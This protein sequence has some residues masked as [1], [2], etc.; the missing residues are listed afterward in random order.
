[1]QQRNFF[2]GCLVAFGLA[3]GTA[4]CSAA[5]APASS[6]SAETAGT[7]ALTGLSFVQASDDY[8]SVTFTF[9]LDNTVTHATTLRGEPLISYGTYTVSGNDVTATIDFGFGHSGRIADFNFKYDAEKKTLDG[10]DYGIF[11]LKGPLTYVQDRGD[12]PSVAFSFGPGDKV[13]RTTTLRGEP[14]VSN[15][16]FTLSGSTLTA[17]IDFGFGHSGR[18]AD[19]VFTYDPKTTT[20][21][22]EFEGTYTLAAD[23]N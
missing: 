12:I 1:M 14:L 8:P 13:T 19:F 7:T 23:A 18:I 3:L 16:T 5:H 17:T 15:G 11:N 9:N 10:G 22:S 6:A 21:E 20:L 2:L 4:G